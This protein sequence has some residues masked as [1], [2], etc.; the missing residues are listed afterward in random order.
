MASRFEC[1]YGAP[2]S[3]KSTAVAHI[4]KTL[5]NATGK[6]SRVMIG[7]G[8]AATYQDM[9]LVDAG[10]VELMDYTIRD[11]PISTLEQL[12]EG[13][14]PA[15]PLDPKSKLIPASPQSMGNLALTC[16]EGISMAG[17]YIMGDRKGGLAYRASKG[18]RIG[19]ESE[20]KLVDGETN[21]AGVLLTGAAQTGSGRTYGGHTISHYN[22]AQLRLANVIERSKLLPG[23]VI[24]TA[25]ERP[26]ENK[27]SG[28]KVIGP[29]GVGGAATPSLP[30]LFGNTLHFATAEKLLKEADE[31]TG[32]QINMID[33]VYR[34]YTRNHFR[35][36][37]KVFTK[38]LATTRISHPEMMPAFLESE[39]AGESILEFY[40]LIE[41]SRNKSREELKPKN[42]AA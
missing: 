16:I 32:Q 14:W 13:A 4:I 36:E 12:A 33:S 17:L 2:N 1:Y 7:D 6:V 31:H 18:E 10:A 26:A 23:W 20:I 30:R 3:A 5:F 42:V 35:A 39:V 41:A 28:E 8:S 40:R 24:W 29:E 25:H 21:A 37:G 19:G 38:Y 34:I 22:V 9:G 15:D 27:L 11:W